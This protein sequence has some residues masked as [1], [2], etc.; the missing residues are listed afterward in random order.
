VF[1]FLC[2]AFLVVLPFLKERTQL[3]AESLRFSALVPSASFAV[4]MSPLTAIGRGTSWS[5][6]TVFLFAF[7]V[8]MIVYYLLVGLRARARGTM[9]LAASLALVLFLFV[10]GGGDRGVQVFLVSV[11]FVLYA[12]DRFERVWRES[13]SRGRIA[14]P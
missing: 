2:I 3:F 14:I 12:V 1:G 4:M 6:T 8:L 7:S 5:S 9:Y 11:G 10:S 13:R